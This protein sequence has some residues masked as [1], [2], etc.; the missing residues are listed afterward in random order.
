MTEMA[1]T[2]DEKRCLQMWFRQAI[3]HV[4]KEEALK[5]LEQ[6]AQACDPKAEPHSTFA[7]RRTRR[8]RLSSIVKQLT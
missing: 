7:A 3:A 1:L 6:E 5:A 8:S 4:E 2:N